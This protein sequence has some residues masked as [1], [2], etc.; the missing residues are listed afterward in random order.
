MS[1]RLY[2]SSRFACL[3]LPNVNPFCCPQRPRAV[4]YLGYVFTVWKRLLLV[5]KCLWYP[6][7]CSRSSSVYSIR[8][9]LSP[10]FCRLRNLARFHLSLRASCS[11]S[12]LR[13]AV[14]RCVASFLRWGGPTRRAEVRTQARRKT[15]AASQCHAAAAC[16]CSLP[17][18]CEILFA[19][20]LLLLS[21]PVKIV[22]S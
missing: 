20:S 3:N 14:G 19:F 5:L 16:L 22:F 1:C 6:V 8:S 15:S 7:S 13:C 10:F 4:N 21:T 2:R 9:L 11:E 17:D 18:Y 12:R